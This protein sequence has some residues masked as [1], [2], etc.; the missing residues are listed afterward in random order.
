MRMYDII[1]KKR[2]GGEL[3]S[4]E[5]AFAVKGFT[6][7][8]IPDAQMSALAM[9]IFFRGMTV[10]EYS[11]LTDEMARSGEM[12]DLSEFG[13]LT[14]DK[15]S[16]GGV[17]DKTTLVLAPM[18]ASLGMKV[19][20]MSGCGL[21]HTG[22]TVD[23]LESIPG[24]KADL[25]SAEFTEQVRDIGIAVSGQSTD[26]APAD[27]KL[28]KLRDE[29]AEVENIPLIASSIMSK[30]LAAGSRN[31]VLDVK[32]GSGAFMKTADEARA[33]AEAMVNIGRENGRRVS[34]VITD[35]DTPLGYA[36]GNSLEVN[37][38][39][40]TLRGEGPRDLR[41]VCVTICTMLYS[42]CF[43]DAEDEA[44]TL[45]EGVLD[46]GEAYNT[47]IRWIKRQ[48][49]DVSVF[50]DGGL[51]GAADEVIHVTADRDGYITHTDCEGIGR[52]A[53]LLGA[54]RS[55]PDG[56]IDHGTG[57]ILRRKTGDA[58]RAGDVICEIY[59]RCTDDGRAAEKMLLDCITVSDEM[60][61]RVPLILDRIDFR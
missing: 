36:V 1:K 54:G 14:A 7:G 19:A 38:A 51:L 5:I 15:H 37:E 52:C 22:G 59:A 6:D 4:E 20:K 30:K 17:G 25:T 32:C 40:M 45:A 18:C 35:M 43:G 48:G 21:G 39:V 16:T 53:L 10:P 26:L 57:L 8:T 50:E 2:D 3:S 58:V 34:A 27:K 12:L 42:M 55:V 13:D 9:A 49:G 41:T 29:C 33:L 56:K 24:F 44:R 47:F 60:G 61:E 28:Y 11:C 31:I 46:S 23:K